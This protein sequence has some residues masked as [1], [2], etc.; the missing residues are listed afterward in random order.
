MMQETINIIAKGIEKNFA[1]EVEN[2]KKWIPS[3]LAYDVL[4]GKRY[5]LTH[6]YD[7]PYDS[8]GKL[9]TDYDS[10]DVNHYKTVGDFLDELTGISNATYLSGHG[11][12]YSTYGEY[13]EELI[14]EK[15]IIT[16]IAYMKSYGFETLHSLGK[17]YL[18]YDYEDIDSLINE[19]VESI[20]EFGYWSH[21]G[22]VHE[23]MQELNIIDFKYIFKQGE[24]NA[25][26]RIKEK[27]KEFERERK[28]IEQDKLYC[29]KL[30]TVLEKQYQL[31]F[32]CPIPK[33]I[34]IANYEP[35]NAF[36]V[37][38]GVTNKERELISRFSPISFSN[39]VSSN[40]RGYT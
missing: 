6:Y 2:I 39:S 3:Q 34:E 7:P 20:E 31:I 35:F 33:R 32:Q 19:L 12:H 28:Q 21:L 29:E 25:R 5:E 9:V 22:C 13:Y 4:T 30:W 11:L 16:H 38:V 23:I 40:L 1:D 37:Q 8:S 24:Q 27:E 17:L 14:K 10:F 18:E 26:K 36:L 15:L